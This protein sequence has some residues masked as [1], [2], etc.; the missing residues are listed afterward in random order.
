M[1]MSSAATPSGSIVEERTD[2]IASTAPARSLAG[3]ARKSRG[4]PRGFVWGA[5]TSSF[6]IEGGR[7]G[8]AESIWDR[9]CTVPGA[10][11]DGS[12]GDVACGH[13]EHAATDVGLMRGLGLGAYRFSISWPRVIP[14]GRGDVAPAGLD[15]YDRLV[16]Q[17]LAAGIEPYVTLY[18]WDLPQTLEDEG[19]WPERATAFHFAEY[20]DAVA[21]A[22]GDRVKHWATLN[23]PY[24]VS[25]FGYTTGFMAP[26]RTS[27]A[28]GFAAAHHLLLGHG[29]AVERLRSRVPDAEVGIV[30]NFNPMHPASSDPTDVAAA[31]AKDALHNRWFAEPIAGLG[32]PIDDTGDDRWSGA[33]ILDSDLA[34]IAVPL[35]VL[36][37]NYYSRALVDATD[38][39][40]EPPGPVTAMGWEIYPEGL[41]ET[42][43]W[44][45]ERCH[46]RR[47]LITENGAAMDDRPDA[48]GFVD[49]Q[50]RIDY[51]R[52]HLQVVRELIDEGIPVG[53]YFAWSLLDNFEWA[54]GYTQRFGLIRVDYDTL[55]RIPK[56]S[57]DWYAG[58]AGANALPSR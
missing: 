23:E 6:Q 1:G 34:I 3:Q 19:G 13:H 10:I 27:V 7:A 28:D 38:E 8:R 25:H 30:L 32:Y 31:A 45:D 39:R 14:D 16:D 43:R 55:E 57:A 50:D 20:A 12:N 15:F 49:D 18:H 54:Y 58:V 41:A 47:Y 9:F 56:A 46:F 42:L 51:L 53:G 33:E 5:A 29:L 21:A 24:C 44:L 17:L 22:L 2:A 37:V 11:L 52:G 26:G 36:G 48:T 35:D 4:F 40:I